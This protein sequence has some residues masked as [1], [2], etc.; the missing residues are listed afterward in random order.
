VSDWISIS[1]K[2]LLRW[3]DD[4]ASSPHQLP[5]LFRRLVLETGRSI[6]HID[7]PSE[8][9]VSTGGF[10]GVVRAGE[11]TAFIP[12]G[13]SLWELSVKKDGEKKASEDYGK[14]G[15]TPDGT[16]TAE[17]AF[18]QLICRPWTRRNDW[19]AARKADGVWRDVL[20]HNVDWLSTWL[21]QAPSSRIWLAE[22]LE[23]PVAGIETAERWWGRWS[24][25]TKPALTPAMVLARGSADDLNASLGRP[26]ILTVGGLLGLEELLACI[27][28]S[29]VRADDSRLARMLVVEDRGSWRRLLREPG[30]LLLVAAD[31]SF[32]E[33]VDDD[34]SHCVVVPVPQN[35]DCNI[36][37]EP[38]KTEEIR[39]LLRS[40][41]EKA[42]ESAPLARQSLIA[43]RRRIARRRELM[44]P[45]WAA[46]APSVAVRAG[47]LVTGWDD[48]SQADRDLIARLSGLTY[49]AA[50]EQLLAMSEGDDPLFALTGHEWHVVS[51]V[52][53][54]RLLGRHLI[55][56]DLTRFNDAATEVLGEPDP[57]L[58]LAPDEQWRA[59]IDG[60]GPKFSAQIRKGT[61]M[62]LA[63]LGSLGEDLPV[64][65]GD[66]AAGPARRAVHALL[67][68]ANADSTGRT[69]ATLSP[70]LPL[71]AEA[72]PDLFLD[73]VEAGL[74]GE[75]PILGTLFQDSDGDGGIFGRHSP[76]TGLLWALENTAWS[77]THFG[78]SMAA[79]AALAMIDPGGRMAN[80]PQASLENVLCV[81][82]PDTSATPEER[83]E[84]ID[85]IRSIWPE[86]GWRLVAGLMPARMSSHHF[87]THTP[88][89]R[90]WETAVKP[91]LM[92]DYWAFIDKLFERLLA[93][94]GS[95]PARWKAALEAHDELPPESRARLRAV[96]ADVDVSKLDSET[97]TE[98]WKQG[99]E[100]TAN[101]AEFPD[102]TWS[103]PADEV[104]QLSEGFDRF[105]PESPVHR[106]AWLFENDWVRLGETDLRGDHNA[107]VE[108]L[109]SRR[110]EVLLEV[111]HGGGIADVRSLAERS[112]T[113]AGAVG[114]ALADAFDDRYVDELLP[115][116]DL[117]GWENQLARGYLWRLSRNGGLE[118]VASVL[119][120]H[121]SLSSGGR[122]TL[123]LFVDDFE[124]AATEAEKL[125]T[126]VGREF[127]R[128]FS[129]LG[130]GS[131]FDAVV[132]AATRMCAVGR[133]AGALD[134]LALYSHN[135]QVTPDFAEAVAVAFEGLIH[136][137]MDDGE[138]RA[139]QSWD[140]ESLFAILDAHAEALGIDRVTRI[141]WY[142]LPALGFEP[143]TTYL[144][145]RL[146]AQPE[147]FVEIVSHAYKARSAEKSEE[148]RSEGARA[149][150]QNAWRL[151]ESWTYTPGYQPDETFDIAALRLWIGEVLP[152]LV[153]ADRLE[154]GST[155]IGNVLVHAPV[156]DDDTWPSEEVRELIEELAS[157]EIDQGIYLEIHNGRGASSRSLTEGGAQERVLAANYR[158]SADRFRGRWPRTAAV[159]DHLADSFEAEA[160]RHDADSERWSQ[161]L[162]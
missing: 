35:D 118:W 41:D 84:V 109:R 141:E 34:T 62:G 43:F 29:A 77:P 155:H 44:T 116:L 11:A 122:A 144:H 31:P 102:A 58:D 104:Q 37:L 126:E 156:G 123:L 124:T 55:A 61:S 56:D 154:S 128:G 14:R 147:F 136:E 125:G 54:W 115:G 48:Q 134:M 9:G 51:P 119:R 93:D 3:A 151:L 74:R 129:Y 113:E 157:D 65:H 25:A 23:L 101:H 5:T 45:G 161:G 82:H 132:T 32:A 92:S 105:A 8:G 137:E 111:E 4:T 94:V 80:R 68:K 40:T 146:A 108:E 52:D 66:T 120:A 85:R 60:I 162:G 78:R 75:D 70:H 139:L 152:L 30:S 127:W 149:A 2:D 69:W 107:Y 57:R 10:D 143:K 27:T 38:I 20:G 83:L 6:E 53:A 142:F 76:H 98:L 46:S 16:P 103:L 72:A 86:I 47:L 95:D 39:E 91:I 12:A 28:A 140:Y 100:F 18:V 42:A 36:N 138:V 13:L 96:L 90:D 145:R 88:Q 159:F 121:P 49:E 81:W 7:V 73:A 64:G 87:P 26:G 22:Q 59:V 89:F 148:V 160:R 106:H 1:R 63:L 79:L 99:R 71:L 130:R 97:R 150:A 15:A 67:T 158:A 131:Q 50:R 135:T 133:F 112:D 110:R 19:S 21:E 114:T 117:E 153:E 17:A 24:S 33:D